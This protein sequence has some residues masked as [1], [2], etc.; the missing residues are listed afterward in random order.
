MA[1]SQSVHLIEFQDGPARTECR[2]QL[3]KKIPPPAGKP[4]LAS[5]LTGDCRNFEGAVSRLPRRFRE[6]PQVESISSRFDRLI[7]GGKENDSQ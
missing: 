4:G 2:D 7:V 1:I 6:D 3:S 5:C